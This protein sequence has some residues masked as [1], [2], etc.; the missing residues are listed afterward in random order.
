VH[1]GFNGISSSAAIARAQYSLDGGDWQ[2]VFPVGLLSDAPKESYQF[3]L[4]DLTAGE[5][6]IAVQ[7]SDRYGNTTSAKT[8]F[9]VTAHSPH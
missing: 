3:Q 6:T 1:V 4:Q 2:A 8:T 9:T 5:H 7:I